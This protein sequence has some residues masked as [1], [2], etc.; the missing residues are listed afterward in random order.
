M[1]KHCGIVRN[2]ESMEKGLEKINDL[3]ERIESADFSTVPMMELYNMALVSQSML[4]AA[5][6]RKESVGAHYRED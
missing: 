4:T 1:V 2:G 5:L 6:A 3:V